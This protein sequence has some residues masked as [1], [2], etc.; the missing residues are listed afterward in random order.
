M[1]RAR[2]LTVSILSAVTAAAI[3][4]A[5]FLAF[6][7]QP[8]AAPD[9]GVTEIRSEQPMT[10]AKTPLPE[11]PTT[12]PTF[13]ELT[14]PTVDWAAIYANT[15]PS[16]V[17]VVTDAGGGS[18]FFVSEDGHVIT[19]HHVV[20]GGD[21]V[22]IYTQQGERVEAE[23]L[24]RDVGNDLALLKVD[25]DGLE[26]VVPAFGEI[27]EIHVGDP[28]GALGAPFGL[29]N[30][31]TVGI[32][33][34][35]DRTRRSGPQTWEPLRAMIQTDAALN[36]GNSGG[37][38]IDDRGRVV[39]IPTQIQSSDRTSS[40]IGFAVSVETLLRSLPT[41]LEGH[42]VERTFLGV[43]LDQSSGRL[44]IEDV[45]CGSAADLADVR[46]GDRLVAIN[47][48]SADTIDELVEVLGS[49]TPG[50]E[51]TITVL[52][53]WRRVE[54]EATAK[55]WPANPLSAGCG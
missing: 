17:S 6:A 46:A 37:M 26:I 47:D 3:T 48:Q 18:G 34:A 24:A 51:I 11:A 21:D 29:P 33:S 54:L 7:G 36:P 45:F 25:P 43:S 9:D 5:A 42:D 16:L 10:V 19:N 20:A 31:L 40:G 38:L 32:V 4:A 55:A 22:H 44:S 50:D 30:T 35:L 12:P 14:R 15:V 52:R 28:V 13:S 27:D 23:I 49:I 1:S 53:N 8:E 41:M 2:S 39:G